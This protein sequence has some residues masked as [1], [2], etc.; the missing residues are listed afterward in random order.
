MGDVD[1]AG[2]HDMGVVLVGPVVFEVSFHVFRLQFSS[3]VSGQGND[4]VPGGFD[5]TGFVM[6]D[7]SGDGRYHALAVSQ[8]SVHGSSI[9][10]GASGQE[11]D[12]GFRASAGRT[13]GQAPF[14]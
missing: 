1:H 12:S 6:V 9:D 8:Y 14:M 3:I 4:L 2:F 13:A 10:L 7:V 11:I 5:S